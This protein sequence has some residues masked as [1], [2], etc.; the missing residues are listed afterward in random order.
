MTTGV[1]NNFGLSPAAAADFFAFR[2]N[3]RL[4]IDTAGTYTFYTNSDD[5]S[6][7]LINRALVVDN[8]GLHGPRE[9]SGSI[10]LG[11][12]L[13][14]VEVTFFE[15]TGGAALTVAYEGG[16]LGKQ[17]IADSQLLLP[18]ARSIRRRR[19]PTR[20]RRRDVVGLGASL[21]ISAVD[22]DGDAL[23]FSA[24]GLPDGLN[25]DA[26]TGVISGTP[27][28]TGAFAVT[29][30]ADD[31][32]SV[33]STSFTWTIV[34][35]NDGTVVFDDFTDVSTLTLNGSAAGS[36]GVLR[37]TGNVG[38][39]AGSAYLTAPVGLGAETSFSSRFEFRVHGSA[40]GADGMAFV[41][42]G[43]APTALGGGGGALGYAG[44]GASV[45]VEIDNYA[46]GW[47]ADANHIAVL[48]G[49][50]VDT[51]H[52][53][54]T[55][56]TDLEDGSPYTLWTDYDG[57]TNSLTVYLAQGSGVSK[58]ATPVITSLIDLPT[59]VGS[60]VHFGFSAGTGGLTNNHDVESWTLTV[61]DGTYPPPN[62]PPTITSP[63]N[64]QNTVA[65]SVNLAIA[66]ADGDG[67]PLT[68]SASGLPV[69]LSIDTTSG[70]ISGAPVSSG[71]HVVEVTV[72]DGADAASVQFELGGTARNRPA[73][74]RTADLAAPRERDGDAAD[75]LRN[76][77][78][79]AGVPL[80]LG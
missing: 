39:Q 22:A 64:Q 17:P 16:G 28:V 72:S 73:G 44:V 7:L 2:F 42:Q 41:V 45:A 30:D 68:F 74:D 78:R 50:A 20:D 63:G 15:K 69:G 23:S 4:Q 70:V 52:A 5:G 12:G 53:L 10:A 21:T 32:R 38:N 49:G 29:V 27:T 14:D 8:D 25:I 59:L 51:H 56:A 34:D 60:A 76:R 33:A 54:Y 26:A 80:V 9:R 57:V 37:L 66:A 24:S 71:S 48:S 3:A 6:Q 13:H 61:S 65:D 31:A 1:T 40:D 62:T 11:V 77:H 79:H 47:D 75:R 18:R 58:P 46:N 67:D 19:S 55:P 35:A 43:N 36:G